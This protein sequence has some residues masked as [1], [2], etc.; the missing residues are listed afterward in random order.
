[1]NGVVTKGAPGSYS[2]QNRCGGVVADAVPPSP[3]Q[4]TVPATGSLALEVA[5]AP[6]VTEIQGAIFGG[7][8]PTSEPRTFTFAKGSARHTLPN[9]LPGAYYLLIT[10][11]WSRPLDSGDDSYA[12]RLI[13]RAP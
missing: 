1:M 12:Y 11:R 10:L 6:E 7:D 5:T 4:V 8:T 2:H 13:V 9:V 3:D